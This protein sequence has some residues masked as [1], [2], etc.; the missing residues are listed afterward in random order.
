MRKKIGVGRS[1]RER[2]EEKER[3]IK[4]EK[5]RNEGSSQRKGVKKM[6]KLFHSSI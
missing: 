6:R 4:E 3:G 2:K 5:K 1:K